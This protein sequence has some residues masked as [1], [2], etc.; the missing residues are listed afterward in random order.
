VPQDL[1]ANRLPFVSFQGETELTDCPLARFECF[2]A[3]ATEVVFGR[4]HVQFRFLQSV[5]GFV[6][7]RVALAGFGGGVLRGCDR[8]E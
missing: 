1:I 7:F 6:E 5:D 4:L 3:M 2:L 8:K